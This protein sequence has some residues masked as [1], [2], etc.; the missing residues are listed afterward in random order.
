MKVSNYIESDKINNGYLK[1]SFRVSLLD[2]NDS[3]DLLLKS[4]SPGV[5]GVNWSFQDD[6]VS[7]LKPSISNESI[8]LEGYIMN[9]KDLLNF[10]TRQFDGGL[11]TN[12]SY[13]MVVYLEKLNRDRTANDLS[14]INKSVIKT[15]IDKNKSKKGVQEFIKSKVDNI[16]DKIQNRTRELIVDVLRAPSGGSTIVNAVRGDF[17]NE[18]RGVQNFHSDLMSVF[19]KTKQNKNASSDGWEQANYSNGNKKPIGTFVSSKGHTKSTVEK[20][21]D[22]LLDANAKAEQAGLIKKDSLV[23][24]NEIINSSDWVYNTTIAEQKGNYLKES[25]VDTAQQFLLYEWCNLSKPKFSLDPSS[26]DLL[27]VSLDVHYRNMRIL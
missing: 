24:T 6:F 2:G 7:V 22:L 1:S 21:A 11:L 27:T 15:L 26:S 5:S 17:V 23:N 8:S 12:K 14:S 13:T 16:T 3:V 9:D 18:A 4:F 20:V 25:Q 19:N 10:Y